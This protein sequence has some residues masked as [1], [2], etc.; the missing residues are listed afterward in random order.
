MLV[1]D[2]RPRNRACQSSG[3]NGELYAYDVRMLFGMRI[4]LENGTLKKLD[5]YQALRER[6][7]QPVGSPRQR[8]VLA[9]LCCSRCRQA[10]AGA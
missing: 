2:P 8:R 5:S 6:G 9:D 4:I 3:R 1:L 10:A 7:C